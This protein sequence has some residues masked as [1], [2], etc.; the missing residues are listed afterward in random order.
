MLR[1]VTHLVR[2]LAT[3]TSG[4]TFL[5]PNAQ[6][7]AIVVRGAGN[8]SKDGHEGALYKNVIGTY[9]HGSILP[10]NH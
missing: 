8:N 9:L 4:Q 7:F 1:K 6:P 2:L 3:K 10:K 5:G